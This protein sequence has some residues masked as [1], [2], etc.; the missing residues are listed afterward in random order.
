MNTRC[1]VLFLFGAVLLTPAARTAAADGDKPVVALLP[2]VVDPFYFTMHRGAQKAAAEEKVELLFQ[3]P[4][5]WNTADQV[6]IL[7]ALI[8]KKPAV[9]LIAPVDKQQLIRPLKEAQDAGIKII[10]VDTYIDDGKYQDGKGPGDFPLSF[11]ASD[12]IEGGRIA[13]RALAKAIGDKGTVYC[14]NNKPG[15]SSTD[16]RVQGFLEEM[17]AHPDIKVLPTQYNEDDANRAAANVSAVLARN[18]TL[19]G[20]FGVNTFSGM[21][22]AEGVKR[23]AQAG[24]VKVVV[25]DAVPGIDKQIKSGLIDIAIAQKP[26]EIGYWGVKYAAAV[27]RGEKVPTER[28]TGFVVMDKTNIDQPDVRQYIYSN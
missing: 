26:A 18:P 3:I 15:I 28:G 13:A 9:L 4:K 11:V 8:A 23:A 21:G 25:F 2:G 1:R 12:N 5:T 6:P 27:A 22:A 14:E 7:R 24:K 10:T 16:Q 19:T 20:V 17:K